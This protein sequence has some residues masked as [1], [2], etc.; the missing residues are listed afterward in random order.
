ME[1]E[2]SVQAERERG[3]TWGACLYESLRMEHFGATKLRRIDQSKP[4]KSRVLVNSTVVL[5]QELTREALGGRAGCWSQG[6]YSSGGYIRNYT[7]MLSR[8]CTW[9]GAGVSSRLPQVVWL[10]RMDAEAAGPRSSLAKLS[11][12][13]SLAHR[14][15][16][17]GL[18][19]VSFLWCWLTQ[20]TLDLEK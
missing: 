17:L 13:L 5:S 3:R 18:L 2:G 4:K 6:I 11:T 9:L 7:S 8:T 19:L 14:L 15:C 12:P 20:F 10:S 16:F 1:G